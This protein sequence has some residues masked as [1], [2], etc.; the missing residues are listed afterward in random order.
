MDAEVGE[1]SCYTVTDYVKDKVGN[2]T[3]QHKMD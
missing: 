3:L 1:F 2:S